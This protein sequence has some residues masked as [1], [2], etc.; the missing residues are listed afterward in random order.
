MGWD[1][2]D[3]G[4]DERGLHV[5]QTQRASEGEV[6]VGREERQEAFYLEKRM[7]SGILKVC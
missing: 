3:L 5:G 6:G 7:T 4:R 2:G 1:L